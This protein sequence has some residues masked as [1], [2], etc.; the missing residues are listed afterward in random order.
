MQEKQQ[1]LNQKQLYKSQHNVCQVSSSP[2]LQLIGQQLQ[3]MHSLLIS[4]IRNGPHPM[5]LPPRAGGDIEQQCHIVCLLE[6][7]LTKFGTLA[8]QSPA[9]STGLRPVHGSWGPSGAQS[10]DPIVCVYFL[11]SKAVNKEK[12]EESYR[13]QQE[14]HTKPALPKGRKQ[15][16]SLQKKVL[17]FTYVFHR[18]TLCKVPKKKNRRSFPS[19]FS[20]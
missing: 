1:L 4:G 2:G 18:N 14:G 12:V 11:A 5:G 3:V 8:S 15:V 19:S 13:L 9:L 20:L 16:V 17:F 10:P 6:E 7:L